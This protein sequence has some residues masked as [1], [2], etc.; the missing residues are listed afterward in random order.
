MLPFTLHQLQILKAITKEKQFKKAAKL[1]YLSQPALSKQIKLLEE[2]VG[3]SLLNRENSEVS[4]TKSGEIFLEY[5][6]RIL[7]L[8][9]ESCR[10]LLDFKNGEQGILNIGTTSILGIYL[11]PK[12]LILFTRT[13][14]L[15]KLKVYINSTEVLIESIKNNEIDIAIIND[16]ISN[17]LKK[18][19]IIENFIKNEFCLIVP[20]FHPFATKKRISKNDLYNLNFITLNSHYIIEKSIDKVLVQNKINLN[21]LKIVMKLNSIEGIKTAVSLGLGVAFIPAYVIEKENKLQTIKILNIKNC[22]ISQTLFIISS[23][24]SEKSKVF[25]LFY[26]QLNKL[27]DN[28]KKVDDFK[29]NLVL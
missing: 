18:S 11:I 21:Q 14:P 8:C 13:Y 20:Y 25:N 17:K 16:E 24:K 12:I 6:E 19:I 15:I 26:K 22:S 9:E 2:S 3:I 5:S 23:L 7:A 1:L 29:K 27:K 4:L 10:V 28:F